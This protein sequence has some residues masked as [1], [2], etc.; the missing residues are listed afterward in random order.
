MADES[1]CVV[2]R[3]VQ[4][5]VRSFD[6]AALR[7]CIDRSVLQWRAFGAHE[8]AGARNTRNAAMAA[9]ACGTGYPLRPAAGRTGRLNQEFFLVAASLEIGTHPFRRGAAADPGFAG[10]GVAVFGLEGRFGFLCRGWVAAGKKAQIGGSEAV[11]GD[12]LLDVSD[13][14]RDFALAEF[15][16]LVLE[17][18]NF[19]LEFGVSRHD[20]LYVGD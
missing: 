18:G 20:G 9:G 3:L 4:R 8:H 15:F 1:W 13:D 17:F 5:F 12:L 11:G 19:L 2:R 16:G 14:F 10:R 6:S 7:P